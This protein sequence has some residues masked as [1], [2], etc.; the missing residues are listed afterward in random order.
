MRHLGYVNPSNV[1]VHLLTLPKFEKILIIGLPSR[2]DRRDAMSLAT[3]LTGL[4]VEYVDGV[5]SVENRTLPPG[6]VERQL[7]QGSIF[8]WRAH[9]NVLRM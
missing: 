2:T 6:G 8:G 3:A 9:M 7:N 5:S 4:S 1:K